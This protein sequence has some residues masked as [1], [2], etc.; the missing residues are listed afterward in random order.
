MQHKLHKTG[1][2]CFLYTNNL[3]KMMNYK[4]IISDVYDLVKITFCNLITNI[5][6][7]YRYTLYLQYIL[8]HFC[9]QK[10][11]SLSLNCDWPRIKS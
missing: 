6:F 9:T 4:V 7:S 10:A 2:Y 1:V 11:F 5:Y 8:K 3:L